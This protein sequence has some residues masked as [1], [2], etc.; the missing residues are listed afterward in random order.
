[1]SFENR[2]KTE[3][4]LIGEVDLLQKMQ[5]SVTHFQFE[6]LVSSFNHEREPQGIR[7]RQEIAWNISQEW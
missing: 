7:K 3:Y 6:L 5:K 1:M 2:V 4:S